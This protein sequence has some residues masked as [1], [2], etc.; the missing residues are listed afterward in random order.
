MMRVNPGQRFG[1]W[2]ILQIDRFG[3]RATC[4]CRCGH[5]RAVSI[6]ELQNGVNRSCGCAPLTS[7][8]RDALEHERLQRLSRAQLRLLLDIAQAG[9]LLACKAMR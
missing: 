3:K 1:H 9:D 4:R 5:L 6:A 8:Q 2:Q 7:K